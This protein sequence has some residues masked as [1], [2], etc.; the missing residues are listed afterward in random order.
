MGF[1]APGLSARPDVPRLHIARRDTSPEMFPLEPTGVAMH[2]ARRSSF[3]LVTPSFLSSLLFSSICSPTPKHLPLPVQKKVVE[4]LRKE[5]LVKQEPEAKLQ[6]HVQTPP[7]G[8]ELKP[9]NLLQGQQI[10]GGLQQVGAHGRARAVPSPP[11]AS[12]PVMRRDEIKRR[13]T[14]NFISHLPSSALAV[15]KSALGHHCLLFYFSFD[16]S[17]EIT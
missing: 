12:A 14:V 1:F 13:A 5:L 15:N 8:G 3:A 9:A 2:P 11:P 6:L 4:Q 7:V 17:Y 10:P 16:L